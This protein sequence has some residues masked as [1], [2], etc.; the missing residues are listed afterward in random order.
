MNVAETM[1]DA[2]PNA[3]AWTAYRGALERLHESLKEVMASPESETL[4][5]LRG[6]LEERAKLLAIN[7]EPGD[8]EN[9]RW[10]AQ[11][12]LAINVAILHQNTLRDALVRANQRF[13]SMLTPTP[14]VDDPAVNALARGG[15]NIIDRALGNNRP[16]EETPEP[17]PAMPPITPQAFV[18]NYNLRGPVNPALFADVCRITA[19]HLD[20]DVDNIKETDEFYGTLGAD[21]LDTVELLMAFE[22][23]FNIEIM[24]DDAEKV[25]TVGDAVR[26]LSGMVE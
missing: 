7:D 1:L 2:N 22:E 12:A 26:L 24:D 13:D 21:S 14:L 9:S 20:L 16:L 17:V 23:E 19:L 10:A 15:R 11:A 8:A 4:V 6:W 3:I 5:Q 18:T 25:V